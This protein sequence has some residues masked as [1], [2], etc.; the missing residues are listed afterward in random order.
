MI[1]LPHDQL[2]IRRW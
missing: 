2:H 1:G